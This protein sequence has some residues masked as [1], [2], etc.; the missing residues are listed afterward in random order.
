MKIKIFLF[1]LILSFSSLAQTD[2]DAFSLGWSEKALLQ[3]P[4]AIVMPGYNQAKIDAEDK[5]ND[6]DKTI[7]WRFGYI[8]KTN[9]SLSNSGQWTNAEEGRYWNAV[10]TCPNAMTINLMLED[11]YLP[12]GATLFLYDKDRTNKIGA[13]TSK[14]NRLERQLGT[15]LIHGETIIVEYFEPIEVFEEG[16]FKITG[17]VHGYRSLSRIQKDLSKGLNDSG[18]CNID[19]NCDLGEEWSTEIRSIAMIIV[20]GNGVCSGALINNTCQDGRPLFLTADHCLSEAT[21]FWAFRF[22]WESPEGTEVCADWGDSVDPGPPYDQTANGATILANA[23]ISDFALL[24]IDNIT[25][26]E[27]DA[28]NVYFS[29]WDRSD[30]ETVNKATGIHHPSADLKKIC[31]EVNAPYHAVDEGVLVWWIDD[32]DFGV[33]EPGSSGSPLFDQNHRI[34]GQLYGGYA[35]CSGTV[36]NDQQDSYG[37]LGISWVNGAQEILSPAMCS[38]DSIPEKLDGFD[39]EN[40]CPMVLTSTITNPLLCYGDI[41]GT[42]SIIASEGTPPYTYD[43]GDGPI[44]SGNFSELSAGTYLITV[45]DSVGCTKHTY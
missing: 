30:N 40:D 19:V 39:P 20:D 13:Y 11:F 4:E 12:E 8:Y 38:T 21:A 14:N 17:V 32:W 15:E 41:N 3:L 10:I 44:D 6:L 26:E 36:D 22:N 16:S 33:T 35:A 43:I 45:I 34:I 9:I 7:P 42:L 5:V 28:W 2:V 24:E 31:Q 25:E 37:R 1:A 29:G 18:A 27:I 23:T